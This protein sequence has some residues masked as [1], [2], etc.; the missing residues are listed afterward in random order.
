[1]VLGGVF[2]A[3]VF[4]VPCTDRRGNSP[5]CRSA[6]S[7]A[8]LTALPFFALLGIVRGIGVAFNRSLLASIN[9]YARVLTRYVL[10]IVALVG[11]MVGLVAGS[12]HR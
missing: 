7:Y 6:L 8:P 12:L 11:G 4:E 1:V 10:P 2:V 5:S 9:L 3:A